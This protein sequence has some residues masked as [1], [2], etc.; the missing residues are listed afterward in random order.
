MTNNYVQATIVTEL[1]QSQEEQ[2][3][4]HPV[5]EA[6]FFELNLM[7]VEYSKTSEGHSRIHPN[8]E[9]SLSE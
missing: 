4:R 6:S 9:E 3:M 1:S 7:Q 5:P 8:R 2:N